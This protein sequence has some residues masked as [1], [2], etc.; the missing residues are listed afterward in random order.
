MADVDAQFR[1]MGLVKRPDGSWKPKAEIEEQR[2]LKRRRERRT[3][4]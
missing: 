2:E 4:R 3:R 1:A